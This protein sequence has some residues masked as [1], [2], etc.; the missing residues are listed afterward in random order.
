MKSSGILNARLA[1]LI[2][3]LGHTDSLVIADAGLPIPRGVEAVDLAVRLGVPGFWPVLDA[4]LAE[5]VVEAA[6]VA[7]E[8]GALMADFER[9]LPV[10]TVSHEELK[11]MSAAAR[12]VVRTGEGTPYANIVL[13]AGVA[14]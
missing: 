1:G 6:F 10:K 7:E 3:G 4:V 12:V 5:M 2:A 13:Q 9:R 11:R 8:A 14:F